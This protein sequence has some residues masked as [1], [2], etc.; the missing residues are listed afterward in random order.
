MTDTGNVDP[1]SPLP[2][3][4]R[5]YGRPGTPAEYLPSTAEPI[6]RWFQA[7]NASN[8]RTTMAIIEDLCGKPPA[9]LV[10]PYAGSGSA[11]I[12]ARRFGVPFYG[13]ELDPVLACVSIGKTLAQAADLGAR[14]AV[15]TGREALVSGCLGL[16][17]EIVRQAT[18]TGLP[19]SFLLDLES[20][21]PPDERSA[22]VQ[23][24][25][26]VA[27]NWSHVTPPPGH[28]VIYTSPPFGPSSPRVRADA[29]L[30]AKVSGL[31]HEHGV[32]RTADLAAVPA[33]SY[34]DLVVALL[35]RAG[36]L[37][38]VTAIIEYEPPDDGRDDRGEIAGRIRAE[39][40]AALLE[41]LETRA[42]SRRGAL[43]LFVCELAG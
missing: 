17:G 2:P 31:L 19:P 15:S 6:D 11:A 27:A 41:I 30:R 33:R 24:D 20:G 26:A 8:V 18:G 12:A 4:P 9:F 3:A 36:R 32:L 16:L 29:R 10:D 23:G 5:G 25:A 43:S 42:F 7:A 38:P 35:R 40:D 22:F 37:G 1:A 34:A 39:T 21:P 28:G 14:G 13:L